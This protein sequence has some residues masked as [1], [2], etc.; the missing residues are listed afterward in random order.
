MGKLAREETVQQILAYVDILASNVSPD[1]WTGLKKLV[2]GGGMKTRYPVGSQII[3]K[4][5]ES[6][7]GT[8]L[9]IPL[10]QAFSLTRRKRFT[11]QMKTGWKQEHIIS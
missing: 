4:W 9:S 1:S 5:K 6:D 3:N 11:M 10:R 2:N 7:N 8:E